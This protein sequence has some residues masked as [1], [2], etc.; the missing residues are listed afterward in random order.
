M[1]KTSDSAKEENL[2]SAIRAAGKSAQPHGCI[3][4]PGSEA[5]CMGLACP[6]NPPMQQK[7]I[8]GQLVWAR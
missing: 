5:T 7:M 2:L 1:S 8:G 6:R 3:C 4:P